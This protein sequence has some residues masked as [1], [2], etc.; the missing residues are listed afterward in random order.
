MTAD[1]R[2][3]NEYFFKEE[4]LQAIKNTN[5]LFE[6]LSHELKQRGYKDTHYLLQ[7]THQSFCQ[8]IFSEIKINEAKLLKMWNLNFL[9]KSK[10]A[11]YFIY[12]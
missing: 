4:Y 11:I 9:N 2:K 7:V 10:Y 6:Q 3:E 12:K 5:D 1:I 8:E